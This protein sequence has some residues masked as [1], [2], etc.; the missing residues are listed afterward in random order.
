MVKPASSFGR[1]GLHDWLIQRL[2]ALVLLAYAL[3]IG[4]FLLGVGLGQGPLTHALWKGLFGATPMKVAT[5][6][7]VF[8]VVAHAW[9]GIWTV[10]T[11]YVKP[12]GVRFFAQGVLV[13]TC[14]SLLLWGLMIVWG[15]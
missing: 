13:V 8:A 6:V 3:Y 2:S 1:S 10:L 15:A 12:V 7:A 5:M 11:D 14:L 4:G 9:I